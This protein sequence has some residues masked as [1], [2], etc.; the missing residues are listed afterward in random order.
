MQAMKCELRNSYD[1]IK[2]YGVYVCQNC[3]TKYSLE[4][5][6][7]LIGVVKIDKTEETEKM[8]VLARR[9]RDEN[10]V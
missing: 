3:E 10:N 9:A 7:K 5:A 8:L 2:Q 1:T 6:K 4:E